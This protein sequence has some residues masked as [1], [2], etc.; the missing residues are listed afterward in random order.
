MAVV[1]SLKFTIVSL[2]VLCL[3][4]KVFG[5]LGGNENMLV[6]GG[7]QEVPV[8]SPDVAR[9]AKLVT[10]KLSEGDNKERKVVEVVKVGVQVVSGTL[11]HLTL[12]ITDGSEE[13]LYEARIWEQP[14]LNKTEITKLEPL[15][16]DN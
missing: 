15:G 12:K 11:T 7:I 1:V 6:T 14:W 5:A 3:S 8:D 2:L 9:L 13:R 4:V 10:D 16:D